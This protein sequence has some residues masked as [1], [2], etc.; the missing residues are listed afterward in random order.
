MNKDC[1][2]CKIVRREIPASIIYEDEFVMAFLDV[3]PAT[4]GHTLVIPKEHHE[5]FLSTPQNLMHQVMEVAQR[6]GQ[7][8]M[9]ALHANG[10]NILINNY[11]LAGQSVMHHHVHVIPRYDKDGLQIEMATHLKGDLNLPS[12]VEKLRGG[13]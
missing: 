4:L 13:M 6:I 9:K 11:P 8:Q 12:V 3:A 10:V 7:V 2:F 5:T 1:V